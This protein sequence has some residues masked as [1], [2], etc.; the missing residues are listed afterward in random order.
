MKVGTFANLRKV[1]AYA[2]RSRFR[3]YVCTAA[4]TPSSTGEFDADKNAEDFVV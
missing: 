4:K 2:R 3:I 1:V